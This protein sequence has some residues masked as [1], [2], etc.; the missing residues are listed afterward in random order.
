MSLL[1]LIVSTLALVPSSRTSMTAQSTLRFE[2][3]A[4]NPHVPYR[5]PTPLSVTGTD[6]PVTSTI[7]E[8]VLG[9]YVV[10]SDLDTNR[11]NVSYVAP[12]LKV[13]APY[14]IG[15]CRGFQVRYNS[16]GFGKSS[17]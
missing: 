10:S 11:W 2:A 7:W 15:A 1:A 5:V 4:V 13:S 6:L 14:G 12:M 16:E 3:Q 17:S 8:V 9:T